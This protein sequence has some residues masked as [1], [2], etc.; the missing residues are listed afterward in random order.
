M[1]YGVLDGFGDWF[2]WMLGGFVAYKLLKRV[3]DMAHSNAHAQHAQNLQKIIEAQ[4]AALLNTTE[5][6]LVSIPIHNA[7]SPARSATETWQ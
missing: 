4:A 6:E 5:P 7:P 2:F 1:K 3:H